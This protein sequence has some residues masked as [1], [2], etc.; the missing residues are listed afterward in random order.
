MNTQ[1]EPKTATLS[2]AL[3]RI[4]EIL[5]DELRAGLARR[6]E[7]MREAGRC[8]TCGQPLPDDELPSTE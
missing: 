5:G 8:P 3:A 2:P 4:V 1:D 7:R 6:D